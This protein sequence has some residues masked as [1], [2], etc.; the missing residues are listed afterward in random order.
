[1]SQGRPSKV[2]KKMSPESGFGRR[3]E[4]NQPFNDFFWDMELKTVW[5]PLSSY[6]INQKEDYILF[7]LRKVHMFLKLVLKEKVCNLGIFSYEILYLLL[8][9]T[10]F[11]L[12]H[13]RYELFI[14]IFVS[15][16]RRWSKKIR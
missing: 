2:K 16:E 6:N 8:L 1:M 7:L 13:N 9:S 4:L 12:F 15:W 10:Y 5:S 14:E 11:E 3:K